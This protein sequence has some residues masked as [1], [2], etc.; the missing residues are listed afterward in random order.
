MKD[1]NERESEFIGNHEIDDIVKDAWKYMPE[2]DI[3]KC[4][5]AMPYH[6]KCFKKKWGFGT[7]KQQKPERMLDRTDP[8]TVAYQDWINTSTEK[9]GVNERLVA[10]WD[11]V[12]TL[13]YTPEE[14]LVWKS[15][16]KA[17]AQEDSFVH[18]VH[19][20]MCMFI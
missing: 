14:Q 1:L 8:K 10:Y 19:K 7:Y 18:V 4:N 12:W 16:E 2:V 9:R 13:L 11:Q 5:E 17:G 20:H 6:T 15:E 3:D